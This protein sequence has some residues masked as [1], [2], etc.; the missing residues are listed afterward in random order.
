MKK[1]SSLFIVFL[2]F[3]H[4]LFA[5]HLR[6]GEIHIQQLS[7]NSLTFRVTITVFT[8]TTNTSVLFGGEDDWLDFGDGTRILVPETLNTVRPDLGLGVA[9]ASFSILHIYADYGNYLISYS[10][11]NRNEGV[12]NMAS[13]VSTKFYIEARMRIEPD[14]LYE[15]PRFL[16][17][18]I[19][20]GI[21]GNPF[22]SS[23]ACKDTNNYTLYYEL[24]TPKQEQQS[25]VVD[26]QLPENFE[27]NLYNGLI[28]WDANF[29]GIPATGEFAFAIKVMQ[30]NN[31]GQLVGYVTRDF[32]IILTEQDFSASFSDDAALDE[33][34]RIYVPENN[35]SRLKV[36]AIG[37]DVESVSM[38]VES[39]LLNYDNALAVELYDSTSGNQKI[40]VGVL[41]LQTVSE[42]VRENPYA[43]NIRM[44]VSKSGGVFFQDTNYL[45]YTLDV[46]LQE[47]VIILAAEEDI[48]STTVYPN[49]TTGFLFF[50]GDEN[51]RVA[52]L[53]DSEGRIL[54]TTN[55]GENK[56]DMSALKAGVYFIRIN[57]PDKP[58]K[59]I[60]VIK[61]QN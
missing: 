51:K 22:S 38:T 33:N 47:P 32:Q 55:P 53:S 60:K 2:F 5:T 56:I 24:I 21:S 43:I 30:V 58:G 31:D 16:T 14:K 37:E 40:K 28:T 4:G 8:N 52:R 29:K 49:P 45:F 41:S 42:L 11:P 26:Y 3:C 36:F 17:P 46:E 9:T 23:I 12:L 15:S 13:S 6:A 44:Q 35:A 54:V 59:T 50:D 34:N 27:L 7:K 57:V 25:N 20:L 18:P 19:F 48:L 61:R 1:A 10:E 39:E